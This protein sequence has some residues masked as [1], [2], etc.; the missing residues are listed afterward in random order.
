MR[1]AAVVGSKKKRLTRCFR[2]FEVANEKHKK[3]AE[4]HKK[5]SF[6]ARGHITQRVVILLCMRLKA[7]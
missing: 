3:L 7:R 5:V 6:H 2:V 1:Q 4:T